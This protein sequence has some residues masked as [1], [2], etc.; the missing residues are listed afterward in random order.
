MGA[1]QDAI[2]GLIL[3]ST[4]LGV[5]FLWQA[6]PL[7][8]SDVFGFVTFGW[9]LFVVDSALTFVRPRMSYYLGLVL[10]ALAL[11]LTLSQ[12]AHFALIASGNLLATFTI[13][14]GSTAEALL[15]ILVGYY[16]VSERR[17]NPWAWPGDGG[18]S[19]VEAEPARQT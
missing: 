12:P 15:I 8:P 9:A 7:L 18:G 14:A 16:A 4:L 1:L 2:R 13:V 17:K 10:G 6:Y 3:F 5:V 19:G 11:S